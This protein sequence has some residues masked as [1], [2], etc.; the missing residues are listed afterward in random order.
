MLINRIISLFLFLFYITVANSQNTILDKKPSF[1]KDS[2]KS[3]KHDKYLLSLSERNL[4]TISNKNYAGELIKVDIN[5]SES[6]NWKNIG[7]NRKLLRYEVKTDI[8]QEIFLN[9]DVVHI[10]EQ[11]E[12][13]LFSPEMLNIKEPIRKTDIKSSEKLKSEIIKGKSFMIELII[14][15]DSTCVINITSIGVII[16]RGFRKIT[17]NQE[18]YG[19]AGDCHN[20]AMCPD[21]SNWCNENRSVARILIQSACGP[22][23]WCSGSLLTNEKRDGRPYFLTAFHCLDCDDNESLSVAEKNSVENWRFDFNYQSRNCENPIFEPARQEIDGAIFRAAYDKTDFALLELGNRPF[24]EINSYYNGWTN[25]NGNMTGAGVV[26]HHPSGDVK[27]ISTW[28][29]V[30]SLKSK[31]WKVKYTD[32]TTEGG[33]SGCP[34]FTS[35]HFVIGQNSHSNGDDACEDS[36]RNWYGN[37]KHSWRD[38]GY[39]DKNLKDWLS[40]NSTNSSYISTM[41]GNETCKENWYLSNANDL[42]TSVNINGKSNPQSAGSR[43]YDGTYNA[44]NNITAENNVIIS[45]NTSV[46]FEAGNS[47]KLGLGFKVE[48]GAIFQARIRSCE[49]GCGGSNSARKIA[50]FENKTI[51]TDN[52]VEEE[53]KLNSLKLAVEKIVLFPNPSSDNL[54]IQSIEEKDIDEILIID[55]L[56]ETVFKKVGMQSPKALIHVGRLN[57]GIYL[58]KIRVMDGEVYFVKFIKN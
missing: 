19:D 57:Q 2:L 29:K 44:T 52:F 22:L 46:R 20:N 21:Y 49:R 56:G 48:N 28:D 40:P 47:I 4:D 35:D 31:Y 6:K 55:V 37:F 16:K 8:G 1:L 51:I 39:A 25:D 14:P 50:S 53:E 10:P 42:H 38:A 36:K 34:L 54:T 26:I 43:M 41:S 58:A 15:K 11:S 27:K 32:G 24:P 30:L 5:L 45:A 23:L 33:S 13:L 3:W 17:N 18:N 7:D 9:M 12:L